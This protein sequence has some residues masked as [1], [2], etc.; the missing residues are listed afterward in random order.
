MEDLGL[1]RN[2]TATNADAGD[3]K[4]RGVRNTGTVLITQSPS[5]GILIRRGFSATGTALG[6]KQPASNVAAKQTYIL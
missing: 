5:L 1:R 4:P 3:K 2:L 6:L